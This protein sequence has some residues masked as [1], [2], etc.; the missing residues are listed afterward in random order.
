MDG[1]DSTILL[2]PI[3]CRLWFEQRNISMTSDQIFQ[4]NISYA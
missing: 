2:D 3:V 1:M 4:Q